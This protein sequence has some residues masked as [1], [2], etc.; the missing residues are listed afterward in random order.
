MKLNTYKNYRVCPEC[1]RKLPLSREYFK[2]GKLSNGKEMFHHICKECENKIRAA[3]EWKDGKLLCHCCGEFKEV[4]EFSPNAGTNPLRN[5]RRSTCRSCTTQRQREIHI[6]YDKDVKLKKCLNSR[7]LG[8]RDRAKKHNI[9]FNLTLEYVQSLW[10][11]QNGLCAI[12]GIPMTY[13][14]QVGRTPTNLSIDKIDREKGYV[15]GNIQ[16]VCMACNQIKSDLTE[17]EMYNFCKKI[18]E[19]YENKNKKSTTAA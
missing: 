6:A 9:P 16:L 8:A 17:D 18:V 10:D 7:V 5:G 15:E 1:N 19:R 2:R 13:E 11:Y 12:S 14:I 3:K 4:D